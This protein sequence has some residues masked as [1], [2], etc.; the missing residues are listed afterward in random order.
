[1]NHTL[2][3]YAAMKKHRLPPPVRT[4]RTWMKC[5]QTMRSEKDG[6]KDPTLGGS[7]NTKKRK[8]KRKSS[9]GMAGR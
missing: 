3:Y 4:V 2:E 1:M 9:T 5:R 7:V 8:Y 6:P